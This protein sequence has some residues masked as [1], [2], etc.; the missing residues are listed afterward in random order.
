ML[1]KIHIVLCGNNYKGMLDR[2]NL[3]KLYSSYL[4]DL[5]LVIAF[6]NK[7]V[8]ILFWITLVYGLVRG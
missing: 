7:I 3:P 2:P 4:S 5:F 6:K 8:A 1:K